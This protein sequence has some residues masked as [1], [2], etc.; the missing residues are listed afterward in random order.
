VWKR[1]V[2]RDLA[3]V[4]AQ[5]TRFVAGHR[6]RHAVRIDD[7]PRRRPFPRQWKLDLQRPL[8]GT[9]IVIRLTDGKGRV[10]VFGH[11]FEVSPVWCHRLVHIEVDLTA[12]R[13]GFIAFE[14]EIRPANPCLQLCTTQPQARPFMTDL[15]LLSLTRARRTTTDLPMLTLSRPPPSPVT[16][17]CRQLASHSITS[18]ICT[19][20]RTPRNASGGD[21][22]WHEDVSRLAGRTHNEQRRAVA[23][24]QECRGR[25]VEHQPAIAEESEGQ[26]IEAAGGEAGRREDA[27]DKPFWA[28]VPIPF[29]PK[30]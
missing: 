17:D 8:H 10:K 30:L 7:A 2:F 9:V 29:K 24:R 11:S 19:H 12:N 22:N 5:S 18:Q 13:T 23:Q 1:F 14:D 3:E 6:L 26:A 4:Q 20:G 27:Q 16:S 28:M 25:Y 15:R 21:R